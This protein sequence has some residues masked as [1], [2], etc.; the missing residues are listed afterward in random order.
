MRIV[1][2]FVKT[3]PGVLEALS[4]TGHGYDAV[5]VGDSDSAYF[6]LLYE[7]WSAGDGFIVVE[8]DVIVRP[9]TIDALLQCSMP[10]CMYPIPYLGSTYP[11][12][13]C[14]KFS[15]SV[16]RQSPNAMARV[17]GMSDATH[18]AKHWCRLDA[19][20]QYRVLPQDGHERHI[21]QPPLGHYRED[22]RTPYPSHGCIPRPEET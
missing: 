11:G 4:D 10:W 3:A 9:D 18:P 6:D 21:H 13:G 16:L 12:L 14:V 2:P 7:L 20:L 15:E 8:Q 1:V 5:Y 17:A 22:G 19:W